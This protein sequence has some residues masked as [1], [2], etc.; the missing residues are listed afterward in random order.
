MHGAP[1]TPRDSRAAERLLRFLPPNV[2]T[3]DGAAY[4][5]QEPRMPPISW[6]HYETTPE[7]LRFQEEI[8][9]KAAAAAAEVARTIEAV[10]W[11]SLETRHGVLVTYLG[12]THV[13]AEVSADVKP[14]TI[15]YR[16]EPR[17]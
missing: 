17:P 16:W 3:H 12:D 6:G 11:A 8:R 2:V 5:D 4:V 14:L 10:C 7:L 15:A 1:R 9:E 13:R